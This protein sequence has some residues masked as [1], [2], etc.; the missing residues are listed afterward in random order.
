MFTKL[1]EGKWQVPEKLYAEWL[2]FAGYSLLLNDKGEPQPSQV[3]TIEQLEKAKVL[4]LKAH[5][6]HSKIGVKT[7]IGQIDMRIRA[8][9]E[10][11][12]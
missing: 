5:E 3:G 6:L 7:K 11:R 10:G 4:L 2:K 8:I 12:V 9:Q 1:W